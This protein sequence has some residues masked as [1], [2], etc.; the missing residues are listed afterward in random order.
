ML[1]LT[2]SGS[3]LVPWQHIGFFALAVYQIERQYGCF[4]SCDSLSS[5]IQSLT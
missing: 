5:I 2:K 4:S 1:A 3:G